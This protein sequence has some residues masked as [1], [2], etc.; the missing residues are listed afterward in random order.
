MAKDIITT[1][2][3]AIVQSQEMVWKN[4]LA[5]CVPT[6]YSFIYHPIYTSFV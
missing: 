3:P 5:Y 2:T 1:V 4:Y 6:G